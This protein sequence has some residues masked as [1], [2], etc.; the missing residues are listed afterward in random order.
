ML[1]STK[2]GRLALGCIE[3]DFASKY[4]FHSIFQDLQY[5]HAFA[6]LRIR[7]LQ[8]FTRFR[9]NIDEIFGFEIRKQIES[10]KIQ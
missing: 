2:R 1:V 9:K 10:L 4:S 8:F 3:A 7:N 6:L 5:R